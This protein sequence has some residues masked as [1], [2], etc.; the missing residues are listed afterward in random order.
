MAEP[1][2]LPSVNPLIIGQTTDVSDPIRY[3]SLAWLDELTRHV[4][5]SDQMRDIAEHHTIGFTQVVSNGPEGDVTY[6]LVVGDGEARFGPGPADPEDARMEQSW[7][8]AVAVANGELNA[9]AAFIDGHIRLHGDQQKVLESQPVFGV[10]DAIFKNVR[11][12]TTYE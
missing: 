6:H 4:E 10:L 1:V 9:H 3:L 8:T 5:A 2:C 11:E 7:D 12:L